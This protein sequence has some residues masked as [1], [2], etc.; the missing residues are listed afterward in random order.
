MFHAPESPPVWPLSIRVAETPSCGCW[1]LPEPDEGHK[2]SHKLPQHH[3][4]VIWLAKQVTG[5]SK[6]MG[7]NHSP[8][9]LNLGFEAESY[10][11]RVLTQTG[12][13]YWGP[14]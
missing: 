10:H 5:S 7:W 14:F 2:S 4:C 9:P 3:L 11:E 12:L 6:L 8:Y 1:I 13:I